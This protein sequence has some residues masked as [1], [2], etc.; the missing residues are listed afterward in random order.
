[1]SLTAYEQLGFRKAKPNDDRENV[2]GN[3]P[4]CGDEKHL[5]VNVNTMQFS[6]KKC[7]V[8]GGFNTWL[9]MIV[10]MAKKCDSAH[11]RKLA[12]DR[13]LRTQ[14]L[15]QYG[16]GFLSLTDSYLMPIYYMNRD[17][18]KKIVDIRHCQLGKPLISTESCKVSIFNFAL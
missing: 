8:G 11:I 17:A 13:G 2:E 7:G 4:F 9:S 1:M 14:T 15:R 6:C 16:V 12:K 10:D 18:E 5:Y 3:C